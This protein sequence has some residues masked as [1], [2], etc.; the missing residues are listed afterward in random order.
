MLS[1]WTVCWDVVSHDN[2]WTLAVV[3][4]GVFSLLAD[5][6]RLVTSTNYCVASLSRQ[7][8]VANIPVSSRYSYLPRWTTYSRI[9]RFWKD[10]G[11]LYAPAVLLWCPVVNQLYALHAILVRLAAPRPVPVSVH[12]SVADH[13]GQRQLSL[14]CCH[15][16]MWPYRDSLKGT[17]LL[18]LGVPDVGPS[19][20][21]RGV[22]EEHW[23]LM[24]R[25]RVRTWFLSIAHNNRQTLGGLIIIIYP[26]FDI[27]SFILPWFIPLWLFRN[28]ISWLFS[29]PVGQKAE[30]V[31]FELITALFIFLKWCD[32]ILMSWL[33][34]LSE[35]TTK[36]LP[37]ATFSIHMVLF[38]VHKV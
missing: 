18:L 35:L 12:V 29:G 23:D 25:K 15:S 21:R 28:F 13:P 11:A 37:K 36:W 9:L 20:F 17:G 38:W 31:F 8:A 19:S 16:R 33:P 26:L 6:I 22:C 7:I 14:C 1:I 3:S 32:Q 30:F 2:T 4:C 24:L 5:N 34:I 27:I 10:T